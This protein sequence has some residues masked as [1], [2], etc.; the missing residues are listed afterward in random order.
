[1]QHPGY[2]DGPARIIRL[3]QLQRKLYWSVKVGYRRTMAMFRELRTKL[4]LRKPY[5]GRHVTIGRKTYGVD[6]GNIFQATAE[7]PVS[8]GSYCSIAASVLFIA[9]GEHPMSSVSSY[10]F[11]NAHRFGPPTRDI[12]KGP[13]TVGN[14]VWIGSRAIVLSGVKIGDGAVVGAGA[15]VTKDVQPYAVVAGNPAKLIRHRFEPT[16]IE[17]LLAIRW[18]DWSDDQ[19]EAAM[20]DLQASVSEFVSK[21]GAA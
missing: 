17:G 1:M 5:P 4:G 19:I 14:D 21:Y 12:A 13:I 9:A 18:W 15:V 11:P 6:F 16:V 8:I 20:P 10:P 3:L 2:L 7:A